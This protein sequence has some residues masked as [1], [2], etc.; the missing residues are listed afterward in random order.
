MRELGAEWTPGREARGHAA[1][2]AIAMRVVRGEPKVV[3]IDDAGDVGISIPPSNEAA[4]TWASRYRSFLAVATVLEGGRG[5]RGGRGVGSDGGGPLRAESG[6]MLA[7][8]RQRRER[9]SSPTE[10]S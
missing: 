10:T 9:R 5:E 3:R 1:V 8:V 4:S 7:S 2:A 6:D